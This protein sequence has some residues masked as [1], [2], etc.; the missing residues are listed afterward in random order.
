MLVK[1]I[2]YTDYNGV[3]REEEFLFSLNKADIFDL[4]FGTEGG[5]DAYMKKIVDTKDVPKLVKLFKELILGAYGEKSADGRQFI[6]SEELS[7]WFSQ[8]EA[9]S[10]LLMELVSDEKAAS[11]FM[12]AVM[13]A[14]VQKQINEEEKLKLANN[15][16]K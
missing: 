16:N 8:T 6:K 12:I 4:Q 5:Y 13:P 15:E 7:K 1:K 14:D 2:K 9:Y 10:N 11:D 3:E